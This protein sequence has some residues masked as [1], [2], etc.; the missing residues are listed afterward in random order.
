MT[1]LT[2]L[3]SGASLG[4]LSFAGV[5]YLASKAR[6]EVGQGRSVIPRVDILT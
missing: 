6:V 1:I 2:I 4:L 3:L 5:L